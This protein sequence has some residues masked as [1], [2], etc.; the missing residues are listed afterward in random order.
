MIKKIALVD[1]DGVLVDFE[2]GILQQDEATLIEYEGRYDEIPGIF[3]LMKPMDDAI[4]SYEWL[5]K[6]FDTYILST[7]PWE[8]N[9]AWNDKHTWVQ[10]YLGEV[11]KKRLTLS[12]NKHMVIGDF[13]IDDRNKNGVDKFT[14]EHIWFG[15][16]SFPN[17]SVVIDYMKAKL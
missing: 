6:N 16:E 9:S 3:G 14:G 17:W 2:S 1:M 15:Q 5:C 7:A 11:A 8:N 10:K 13:L 4:E 12:H